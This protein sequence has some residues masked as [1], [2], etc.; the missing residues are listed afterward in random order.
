MVGCQILEAH[1]IQQKQTVIGPGYCVVVVTMVSPGG[2]WGQRVRI[3]ERAGGEES[4]PARGRPAA[5]QA[6][7]RALTNFRETLSLTH[8]ETGGKKLKE[9]KN[10]LEDSMSIYLLLWEF[11]Y[12]S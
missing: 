4:E 1:T 8:G 5:P 7:V 2:G 9:N 6:H 10:K 11:K 12:F 3:A